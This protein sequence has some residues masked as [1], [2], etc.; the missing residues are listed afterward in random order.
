MQRS[1]KTG[2]YTD[3]VYS[4]AYTAAFSHAPKFRQFTSY[5]L[6]TVTAGFLVFT[7]SSSLVEE[8]AFSLSHCKSMYPL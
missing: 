3:N 1:E 6:L 7:V 5:D 2:N 8:Y 4:L